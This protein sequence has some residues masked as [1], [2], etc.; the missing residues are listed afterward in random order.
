M[1]GLARILLFAFRARC[2]GKILTK[3][4]IKREIKMARE[5]F[6]KTKHKAPKFRESY[7]ETLD[8]QDRMEIKNGR[9]KLNRRSQKQRN[10]L[11][12]W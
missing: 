6:R 9:R 2:S 4:K 10:E 12:K 1:V 8:W 5:T 11:E 7:D 3:R